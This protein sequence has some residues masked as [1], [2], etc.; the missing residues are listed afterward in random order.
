M[1]PDFV[2]GFFQIRLDCLILCICRIDIVC[3]LGDCATLTGDLLREVSEFGLVIGS[4][5]LEAGLGLAHM[6]FR[7]AFWISPDTYGRVQF[8]IA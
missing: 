7:R 1:A 8:L 4:C 3:Y 2:A 5:D 6:C